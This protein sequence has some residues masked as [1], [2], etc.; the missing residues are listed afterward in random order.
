MIEMFPV[1]LISVNIHEYDTCTCFAVII[2]VSSDTPEAPIFDI[3]ASM[4]GLVVYTMCPC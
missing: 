4:V 3:G 1:L 2:G